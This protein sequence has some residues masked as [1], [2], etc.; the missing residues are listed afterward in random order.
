MNF[1]L[2][3]DQ[4]LMRETFARFFDENSGM[5]QVRAAA[6]TGTALE[7]NASPQRL[8][9]DDVWAR[10][11]IEIGALLT[12][13]SDAHSPRGLEDM[14]YGV[15]QA[16]RGWVERRHVLNTRSAAQLQSW[17]ADRA[18]ANARA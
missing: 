8:D 14:R 7:V 5:E 9:L 16:R 13:S 17:L 18:Q 2:S 11:A 1:D 12:I 10:R 15:M 6:A 4:R 3:E